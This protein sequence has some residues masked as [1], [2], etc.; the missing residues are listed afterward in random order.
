M[1]IKVL[2]G[3]CCKWETLLANTKEAVK[4]NNF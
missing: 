2:G 4:L 3:G 1:N